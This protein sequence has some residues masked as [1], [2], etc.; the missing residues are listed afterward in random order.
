LG[1]GSLFLN[2]VNFLAARENLIGVE[3]RTFD[4]PY[5]NMTNTQMKGTFIISLILVPLLMAALGVAV[6]WRRR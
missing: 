4:L 1:N 3:P 5:V 2:S 6:W